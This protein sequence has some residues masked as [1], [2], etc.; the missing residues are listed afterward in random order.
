MLH[1]ARER[2]DV[3]SISSPASHAQG[4]QPS[5]ATALTCVQMQAQAPSPRVAPGSHRQSTGV[6]VREETY[7]TSMVIFEVL[8]CPNDSRKFLDFPRSSL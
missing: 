1:Q 5:L 6:G 7:L 4:G 2:R 3:E 8:F